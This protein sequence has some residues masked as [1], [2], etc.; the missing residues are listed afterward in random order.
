M[1]P[2]F[3]K[4]LELLIPIFRFL[5]VAPFM[6]APTVIVVQSCSSAQT[7][8]K[9]KGAETSNAE[10]GTEAKKQ[11]KKDKPSASGTGDTTEE[12]EEEE[13]NE[14]PKPGKKTI[15]NTDKTALTGESY[16]STVVEPLFRSSCKQCHAEPS[17]V[18][19]V[20][21]PLTIF[22]YTNM[23]TMIGKGSGADS[24]ALIEKI[25]GRPTHP[26]GDRCK[27]SID[28]SP[29][30]E[31]VEWW[32]VINGKSGPTG[33]GGS[34]GKIGRVVEVTPGGR[35]YGWAVNPDVPDEQ[36]KV[37]VFVGGPKGQGTDAGTFDAFVN[38][39]DEDRPGNHAFIADLPDQFR[40]GKPNTLFAYAVIN[41]EDKPLNTEPIAYTAW[42]PTAAGLAFFNNTVRGALNGC[43]G[44]HGGKTYQTWYANLFNPPPNKGG[45]ASNN[46]LINKTGG[47]NGVGHSGG[48]SCGG[49][50]SAGPCA[51]L[52]TWW[53]MEF[54]ATP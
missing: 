47:L 35:V 16:F 26:G 42:A 13:S 19:G 27:G 53:Q 25:Q 4:K 33:S 39:N 45:T 8:E 9:Q 7:K 1:E 36:V 49:N 15:K 46:D 54:G 31:V 51:S 50:A 10:V 23:N 21:A 37:K 28:I 2:K 52:Q 20:A 29:C 6:F 38:G 3:L 17:K 5:S 24:N 43:N 12:E 14:S 30:K 44:C 34:G 40:N 48:N 41:G 11:T 18:A 32:K 22:S